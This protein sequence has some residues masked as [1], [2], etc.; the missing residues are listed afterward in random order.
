MRRRTRREEGEACHDH[1]GDDIHL[2]LG[3]MVDYNCETEGRRMRET[4]QSSGM[5]IVP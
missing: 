4:E 3:F 2:E 1:G 5:G